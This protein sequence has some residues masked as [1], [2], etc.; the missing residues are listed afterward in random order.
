M[1]SQRRLHVGMAITYDLCEPGGGVKQ[2]ARQLADSLRE[3]GDRVTLF[4]PASRT[5]EEP[6]VE[7]FRGVIDVSSNGSGNRLGI[8]VSPLRFWRFIQR[9]DFDILHIHE[10][11]PPIIP[12]YA[13]W[14]SLG[15]PKIA[16]FHAY[17]ERSTRLLLAARRL[18]APFVLPYIHRG[19]AVSEP[20]FRHARIDWRGP[21]CVIPN[22]IQSRAFLPGA[23]SD[24]ARRIRLLFV[25]RTVDQRKGFAY[26]AQAA[27]RARQNGVHVELH[28][29][30][31]LTGNE[32]ALPTFAVH[33]GP[34][35][36]AKLASM[37]RSCD[38]FV[39][40]STGQESFGMVLL[41]AMAAARPIICTSIDGY[42][43][44]ANPEGTVFVPPRDA[45]ALTQA[46]VQLAVNPVRRR[47][48]GESNAR[49]VKRFDWSVLTPKIRDE[50]LRTIAEYH[51]ARET[52]ARLGPRV[53]P[54]GLPHMAG[55]L[56]QLEK[57]DR[58]TTD[59]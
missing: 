23:H 6:H 36:E 30:G 32:R 28:L 45:G 40:P 13:A 20:A 47:E 9:Q 53:A 27:S 41:E 29:V 57:P 7:G 56:L 48:M 16:T 33:H 8:L 11:L 46:I 35:S 14:M 42:R 54:L 59:G 10:P 19:I 17:A 2:S 55:P 12:Y 21:L 38:V 37:Y 25:G 18:F 24:V 34:L 51:R 44:V 4:G 1:D 50:Y 15:V 22:G 43:Q 52:S 39:A 58:R 5:I 26:L 31:E 49:F 3:A